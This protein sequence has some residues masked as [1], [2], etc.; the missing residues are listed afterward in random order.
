[1]ASVDPGTEGGQL[2]VD[3]AGAGITVC[4]PG[5]PEAFTKAI[6]Q[7]VQNPAEARAMGERGREFVEGWASP[8]AVAQAYKA[9]FD[10]NC[11]ADSGGGVRPSSVAGL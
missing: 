9:L 1:M 2:T 4:T 10:E 3:A 11:S 5:D 6:G 7:L 8:A